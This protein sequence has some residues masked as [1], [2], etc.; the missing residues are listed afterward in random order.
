MTKK[1]YEIIAKALA[2]SRPKAENHLGAEFKDEQ[3]MAD[4]TQLC[5]ALAQDNPRFDKEKF[6]HFVQHGTYGPR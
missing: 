5:D 1:E 3:W 2:A 6:T 4:V